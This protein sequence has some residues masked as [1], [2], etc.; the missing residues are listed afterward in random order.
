M[1][2]SYEL[3]VKSGQTANFNWDY[4]LA[5]HMTPIPAAPVPLPGAFYLFA[6]ALAGFGAFPGAKAEF[7]GNW[8]QAVPV[9]W[10][11]SF[12]PSLGGAG[13]GCRRKVP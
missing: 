11:A 8:P 10:M 5:W 6:S 13:S 7:E 12:D 4:A 9:P 2:H 3:L 1:G